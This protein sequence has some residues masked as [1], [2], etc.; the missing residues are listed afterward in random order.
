MKPLALT[1]LLLLAVAGCNRYKSPPAP[2][3]LRHY[4]LDNMEGVRAVT[5]VQLD[6]D[7]SSDGRGALRIDAKEPMTVPLFEV[8]GLD[9]DNAT[10]LYQAILQSEGLD[11]K[12]YLEMWVRFPGKGEFFSRGLDQAVTGSMSWKT[13]TIPFFLKAGEKPDLVRLNVVV[14]GKGRVWVDDILLLR[15]PL[16]SR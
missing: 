11:G 14:Q 5:G 7:I 15:S 4:P 2:V 3:E 6:T 8:T 16:P 13:T 10:L 9:V 12:A 1:L